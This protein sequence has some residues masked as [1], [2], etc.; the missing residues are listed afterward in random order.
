M[1]T[2]INVMCFFFYLKIWLEGDHKNMVRLERT[3]PTLFDGWKLRNFFCIYKTNMA[4]DWVK[5][6]RYNRKNTDGS[7]TPM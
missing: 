2:F 5:I 7:Q 6:V 4:Y 3:P 1:H